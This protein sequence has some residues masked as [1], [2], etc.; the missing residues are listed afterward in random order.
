[1][2][3]KQNLFIRNAIRLALGTGIAAVSVV[4]I[5]AEEAA[6]LAPVQ[7]T[8]SRLSLIE[9]EGSNPVTVLTREDITRVGYNSVGQLLQAMPSMSG[10]PINTFTNNGGNG[11]TQVDLRGLGAS[12]TLV[13]INGR[14]ADFAGDL[15]SF[16][17]AMVERIEVLKE[18]ASAIYGADAVAGVVNIITRSDFEG[19]EVSAT[20]SNWNVTNAPTQRFSGIAGGNTDHGN[21]VF[22]FDFVEQKEAFQDELGQIY[23][24][25]PITVTDGDGYRRN[26]LVTD[27]PNQNAVILGSSSNP[28][29]YFFGDFDGDGSITGG[30]PFFAGGPSTAREFLTLD[31]RFTGTGE[32]PCTGDSRDYEPAADFGGLDADDSWHPFGSGSCDGYNFNPDNYI[33][34]PN[35]RISFFVQGTHEIN[36]DLVFFAEAQFQRRESEQF[37]APLPYFSDVGDPGFGFQWFSDTESDATDPDG[38][39]IPDGVP[40]DFVAGNGVSAANYYNPFGIDVFARRRMVEF[41][42]RRFFQTRDA[43]RSVLG[44]N[45]LIA[46]RWN[47]EISYNY[48]ETQR[49]DT[50]FG[51]FY[52]P[53]LVRA[54]GPSFDIDP[55]DSSVVPGVDIVCGDPGSDGIPGNDDD[56]I[57]AGCV[58]LNM[59]GGPGT[60]TQ[61]MIDYVG[62][63]LNDRI[64]SRTDVISASI[65]GDLVELPFGWMQGAFGAERRRE[66]LQ[67][68]PDSSKVNDVV[69]GNTGAITA[70]SK[71]INSVFVEFA[72]PL[73]A[74]LPMAEALNLTAGFRQDKFKTFGSANSFNVGLKW[75][76]VDDILIRTTIGESFRE[77]TIGDLFAGQADSFPEASDPCGAISASGEVAFRDLTS[78]QQQNCIDDGV[79]AGGWGD[80]GTTQIRSRVGGNAEVGPEKGESF[81]AGIAWSPSM[82]PGFSA[83]LDYWDFEVTETIGA[84]AT[85]TILNNCALKGIDCDLIERAPGTGSIVAVTALTDNLGT[86][87]AKGIDLE[88]QYAHST[89]FGAFDHRLLVTRLTERTFQE[90]AA[91]VV[92]DLEGQFDNT[93]IG[94]SSFPETRLVY[95]ADWMLGAFGASARLEHI[96]SMEDNND[97]GLGTLTV[98]SVT[99]LDLTGQW[100]LDSG[101]TF[102]VGITNVTDEDPPYINSG[103][104]SNVDE[105]V[106]RVMGTGYFI[107]VTQRFD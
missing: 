17:V 97:A 67:S 78:E 5:A 59:F 90:S 99:Y 4:G 39:P 83:L 9:L 84:L 31:Y 85:Q 33:Q 28:G 55:S 32:D 34:T 42:G 27:G 8:G 74:D 89:S 46:D 6:E 47:Y 101:T 19:M 54:L 93:F 53:N 50:D 36:D 51:Q 69:T 64:D 103:F 88:L 70:G 58:P 43:Y 102:G 68:V 76:P 21:F 3:T 45:G 104:N 41:S 66:K 38:N 79:P 52:G 60:I 100:R 57:I 25:Y 7:V 71:E 48:S 86:L 18:G 1:M 94:D 77:P 11:S 80:G 56:N 23:M 30:A 16:P 10:S 73:L 14:R 87:T 20:H 107:R 22:G 2:E 29:G 106:H 81:T 40:D 44:V 37:L 62:V 72:A 105:S 13:L 91:A 49:T 24:R 75:L 35:K 61:A 92:A 63:A 82:L 95:T 96:S 98:D 65:S 15:N 26:G 12:R